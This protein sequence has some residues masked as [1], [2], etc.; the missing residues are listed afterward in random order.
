MGGKMGRPPKREEPR[1]EKI[2][3]RVTK[4]ELRKIEECAAD[5][6][7]SRTDAIM[8]GINLLLDELRKWN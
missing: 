5:L 8:R 2:N 6:H 1:T 7:S 3:L 4:T